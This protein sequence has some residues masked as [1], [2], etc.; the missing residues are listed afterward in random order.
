MENKD[1][2]QTVLGYIYITGT[3][4]SF[5][6]ETSPQITFPDPEVC[7]LLCFP[8]LEPA[9]CHALR[10]APRP[11]G[12]GEIPP[13]PAGDVGTALA[14]PLSG[15]QFSLGVLGL[16]SWLSGLDGR[17]NPFFLTHRCL[18]RGALVHF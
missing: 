11:A 2:R 14:G 4:L 15:G 12:A 3:L 6:S 8:R 5:I 9:G 16:C 7:F 1:H 10:D 18:L 13:S 17:K